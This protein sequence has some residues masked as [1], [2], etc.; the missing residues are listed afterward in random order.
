MKSP[1]ASIRPCPSSSHSSPALVGNPTSGSPQCPY[2]TTPS[3]SFS[4]CEYQRCTSFFILHLRC[5]FQRSVSMPAPCARSNPP[6]PAQKCF[7]HP[8]QKGIKDKSFLTQTTIRKEPYM[9]S[10]AAPKPSP[11]LIF[12]SLIAYQNAFALKAAIE[13]DFF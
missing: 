11:E 12:G 8:L 10:A 3:S 4:R 1:R 6:G 5:L 9:S 13:V 7:P 2:T